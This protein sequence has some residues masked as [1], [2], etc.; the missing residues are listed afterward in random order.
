[1]YLSRSILFQ[2]GQSARLKGGTSSSGFI[3]L[4]WPDLI[5]GIQVEDD[6][7]NLELHELAHAF[8]INIMRGSDF[9]EKFAH[10]F[11][12]WQEQA[13]NEYPRIKAG[14]KSFLRAYGGT[15]THEFFAVCVEH[16]FEAPLEFSQKLP[17][18]TTTW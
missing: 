18:F 7:I 14:E 12:Y 11:D 3:L 17:P 13:D 16:F 9:D 5:S 1:L 4:S 15:N 10:Y 6:K 2:A 8:E